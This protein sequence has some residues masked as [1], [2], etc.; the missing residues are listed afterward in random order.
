V[1]LIAVFIFELG[2]LFCAI[3]KSV[4]FLIFGRAIAGVGAAGIFVS[5]FTIIAQI[6]RLKDRPM[7]I[8]FFG[9]MFG[10]SSVCSA[11]MFRR[12]SFI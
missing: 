10:I 9:G 8:G 3:A 11:S 4:E 5:I 1:Y 2:S 7:F 12:D 6:T